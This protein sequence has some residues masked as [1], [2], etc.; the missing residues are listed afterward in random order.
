MSQRSGAD[1]IVTADRDP[2][3]IEPRLQEHFGSWWIAPAPRLIVVGDD[4]SADSDMPEMLEGLSRI[5]S[6]V[7]VVRNLPRLARVGAY[8]RGLEERQ[9][10]AVLVSSDCVVGA[11]WLGEL[12][13]GCPFYREDRVCGPAHQRSWGV[14][15]SSNGQRRFFERNRRGDRSQRLRRPAALDYAAEHQRRVRLSPRRDHRC[16]G[17]TQREPHVSR[18]GYQGL[19]MACVDARIHS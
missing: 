14:F 2:I 13:R 15:G 9:G 5:D 3:V 6:R 17:V 8:N 7:H 19:G 11:D 4:D 10:D 18:G 16:R 12:F 1:V